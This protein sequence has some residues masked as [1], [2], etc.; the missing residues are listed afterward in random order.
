LSSVARNA[1]MRS[2]D[3][4]GCNCSSLLMA[5]LLPVDRGGAPSNA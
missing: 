1:G 5:Q 2:S 3:G 4:R